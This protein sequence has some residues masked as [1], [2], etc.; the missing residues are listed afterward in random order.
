MTTGTSTARD[1]L[2]SSRN[3]PG[4]AAAIAENPREG[5]RAPERAPGRDF[6]I[7]APHRSAQGI[8][9]DAPDQIDRVAGDDAAGQGKPELVAA[10]SS[11]GEGQAAAFGEACGP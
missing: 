11:F 4:Q 8:A 7:C 3:H 10:K 6:A 5:S 9:R 2:R 1:R